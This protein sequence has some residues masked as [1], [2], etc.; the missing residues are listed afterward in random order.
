MYWESESWLK[1]LKDCLV[2][3]VVGPEEV[4]LAELIILGHVV[5]AHGSA[6]D[7]KQDGTNTNV[8][9]VVLYFNYCN[10][11]LMK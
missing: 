4:S 7:I 8:S 1:Y 6:T 9:S 3:L 5:D 10:T 2:V 11:Q